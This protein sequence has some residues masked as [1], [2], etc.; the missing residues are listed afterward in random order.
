M[1]QP[2]RENGLVT[3]PFSRKLSKSPQYQFNF[4]NQSRKRIA[5]YL[6]LPDIL[7]T[8]HRFLAPLRSTSNRHYLLAA[9]DP[10]EPIP[11]HRYG[12]E[13]GTPTHR[14]RFTTASLAAALKSTEEH[15]WIVREPRSGPGKP[16]SRTATALARR[17]SQPIKSNL[18]P[19]HQTFRPKAVPR[20]RSFNYM[21]TQRQSFSAGDIERTAPIGP[22]TI[23]TAAVSLIHPHLG[24]NK[25]EHSRV[26]RAHYNNSN[27]LGSKS[28]YLPSRALAPPHQ[29][30]EQT[31]RPS[32][33]AYTDRPYLGNSTSGSEAIP[34]ISGASTIHIDGAAL[35]RWAVRH[36]ERTLS[37]PA[38]GMTGVDPRATLPRTRVSPF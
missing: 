27:V 28:M 37:K 17:I 18:M 6:G 16:T 23:A 33:T 20:L 10:A 21:P 2:D 5:W 8:Q 11:G 1:D 19:D 32:T 4:L 30:A 35:G 29:F 3:I 12:D 22:K 9:N 15:S 34:D 13:P 14:R 24:S 25:A 36:L 7:K 26:I 38:V 31:S